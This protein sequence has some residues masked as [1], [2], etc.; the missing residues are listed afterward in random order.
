MNIIESLFLCNINTSFIAN[1]SE[2]LSKKDIFQNFK[3]RHSW[4]STEV[5][6]GTIWFSN[7]RCLL[8]AFVSV[9]ILF[10]VMMNVKVYKISLFACK[11]SS[12]N[13]T[14]SCCE[15]QNETDDKLCSLVTAKVSL[16][17]IPLRSYISH[18]WYWRYFLWNW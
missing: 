14:Q 8:N 10:L 1:L 18:Y 9:C 3:R 4:R 12:Q 13:I 11:L 15:T 5:F 7:K 16:E 6:P 17:D 2:M